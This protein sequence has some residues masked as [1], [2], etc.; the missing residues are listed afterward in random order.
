MGISSRDLNWYSLLSG[1]SSSPV[2]RTLV[3]TS[4]HFSSAA[5]WALEIHWMSPPIH[6]NV[7]TI[8]P[9]LPPT[10]SGFYMGFKPGQAHM[11]LEYSNGC[12]QG[13]WHV[14]HIVHGEVKGQTG[15]ICSFSTICVIGIKLQSSAFTIWA[16]L[17]SLLEWAYSGFEDW[18]PQNLNLIGTFAWHWGP[19]F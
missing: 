9:F 4:V 11:T 10:H 5:F 17:L 8:P 13:R 18:W 14:C 12:V 1:K 19:S 16:I 2:Q 3:S 6:H 7:A 15:G